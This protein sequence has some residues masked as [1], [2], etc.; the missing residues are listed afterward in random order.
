[1][2]KG[3]SAA[4]SCLLGMTAAAGESGKCLSAPE[5]ERKALQRGNCREVVDAALHK[6]RERVIE[7]HYDRPHVL[8]LLQKAV[9]AA[10]EREVSLGKK[11]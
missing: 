5:P 8:V 9:R 11:D 7:P 3:G 10:R 1:M 4:G 6:E 2:P